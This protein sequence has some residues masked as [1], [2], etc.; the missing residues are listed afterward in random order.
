[1]S[2]IRV[3]HPVAYVRQPTQN[4][5]WAAATAM[6]R[7]HA[8][9]GH[10]TVSRVR[11]VA[12]D[13]RVRVNANGSLPVNDFGNTSKLARA[14]GMKCR[15]VRVGSVTSLTM[16]KMKTYLQDGRLALFG[17]FDFPTRSLNH[18]IT[19]YRMFGDGTP[20]G[21]TVSIVDPFLGRAQNFDW[22]T[23]DNDI[24]AD[25]HFVVSL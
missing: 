17:F 2:H 25:P 9:G 12:A 3:V 4:E 13:N 15:D 11:Q 7:G 19:I 8:S 10:Y 20:A 18:V 22:D 23:F 14:M 6:A 21:T 1:M 24:M 5:C 16:E